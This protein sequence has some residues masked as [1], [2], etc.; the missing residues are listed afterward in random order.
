MVN[1]WRLMAHNNRCC[2]LPMI[3]WAIANQRIALGWGLIGDVRQYATPQQIRDAA[4]DHYPDLRNHTKSAT[5]CWNFYEG[6][7]K[8]PGRHFFPSA[9][10]NLDMSRNTMQCGD[11]VI[12]KTNIG[13]RFGFRNSVVIRVRGPYE[14]VAPPEYAN[15]PEALSCLVCYGYQHQRQ[16]EVADIDPEALWHAAR[17]ILPGQ[18]K[19]AALVRCHEVGKRVVDGLARNRHLEGR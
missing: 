19:F 5:S 15:P 2:H 4:S 13:P 17:P 9:I 14:F 12:L 1:V 18:D 7:T 3:R 6:P 16:A 10:A 8:G 11:L